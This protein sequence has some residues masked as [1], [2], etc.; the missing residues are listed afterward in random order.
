[1]NKRVSL[2]Y[3]LVG[4][5]VKERFLNEDSKSNLKIHEEVH[6]YCK[7]L[8]RKIQKGF[9]P[10]QR[11]I[12][13][14][15][16]SYFL[17][18]SE[19][20]GHYL[21]P[22]DFPNLSV[23]FDSKE[24]KT[25]YVKENL[26]QINSHISDLIYLPTDPETKLLELLPNTCKTLQSAKKVPYEI[27]FI[28]KKFNGPDFEEILTS[29]SIQDYIIGEGYEGDNEL[30][31]LLRKN[32]NIKDDTEHLKYS[33][34]KEDKM[35]SIENEKKLDEKKDYV[36]KRTIK[37]QN[38]IVQK[39]V[40]RK[41][42]V[43]ENDNSNNLSTQH[44]VKINI[45]NDIGLDKDDLQAYKDNFLSTK[46]KNNKITYFNEDIIKIDKNIQDTSCVE[47]DKDEPKNIPNFKVKKKNKIEDS[48][49]DDE[50]SKDIDIQ[51]MEI[52]PANLNIFDIK[53][54]IS[55][56]DKKNDYE[57]QNIT[58]VNRKKFNQSIIEE[59]D[60]LLSNLSDCTID[61]END[62]NQDFIELK[63]RKPSF[64]N[65]NFNI[66]NRKIVKNQDLENIKKQS[67]YK[68]DKYFK[69]SSIIKL[70]DDLRQ[71][72]L[73]L[74]IISVLKDVFEENKL[75]LNLFPYKTISMISKQYMD[76]GGIIEVVNDC[77]S[78]DM[79][80]RNLGLNLYDF[81]T[82][83]FGNEESSLF[84]EARKNFVQSLAAYSVVSYILNIKDRH[85][86]NIL[87]N[88]VGHIIHIDFGF[89]FNTS[90]AGNL[91]FEKAGFKLTKEMVK[92]MGGLESEAYEHFVELAIRGFLAARDNVNRLLDPVILMFNSGMEC[93]RKSSISD[94]INRFRLDL[95]EEEAAL[96]YKDVIDIS[97]DNWR[98]NV[99]DWIQ[100]KQ[101]QINY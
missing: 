27:G 67:I 88:N 58:E 11:K 35:V 78:R 30:S 48:F 93:F 1:M 4:P 60:E 26:K 81:F 34:Y 20:S 37:K 38:S 59:Q 23:K 49:D 5:I 100:F 18:I 17:K 95:N 79:I 8:L 98:T 54:N 6:N 57:N 13:Y 84:R 10:M 83:N 65:D 77:E 47:D 32:T 68:N 66:H 2:F 3:E 24:K 53:L 46:I 90:P 75:D 85:N 101:N 86:G 14:E 71:D 97:Y 39:K 44:L 41:F 89:I 16:N 74:Q 40:N 50:I 28:G 9:N 80:Q 70:G 69:L 92:I 45:D 42:N 15:V 99:Y 82:N 29:L 73:A 51:Q 52:E 64:S 7:L 87:I 56:K 25:E 21:H 96:F 55:E 36:S 63:K 76:L 31:N 61:G 62:K 19:P 91:G 94:M 72:S 33:N 43:N 12:F 22:E